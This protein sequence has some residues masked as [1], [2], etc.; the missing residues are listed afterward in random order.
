MT[1]SYHNPV[2]VLDRSN[3]W[4]TPSFNNRFG[5]TSSHVVYIDSRDRDV[6]TYPSA[7]HF[8][9]GFEHKYKNIYSIELVKAIIPVINSNLHETLPGDNVN[10]VASV[11]IYEPYVYVRCPQMSGMTDGTRGSD[12]TPANGMSDSGICCIPLIG[13]Y[14]RPAENWRIPGTTV[15]GTSARYTVY[16]KS[17]LTCCIKHFFPVKS[18]LQYL[19]IELMSRPLLSSPRDSNVLYPLPDESRL[20]SVGGFDGLLAHNNILLLFEIVCQN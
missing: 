11:D 4:Q 10:S 16:D 15:I 9:I 6:L 18:S 20:L 13:Q 19:D 8:R 14:T 1:E 7:N 5:E 3:H 2:S 17:E 12:D